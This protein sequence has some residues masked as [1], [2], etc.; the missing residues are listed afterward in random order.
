MRVQQ[1]LVVAHRVR[2]RVLHVRRDEN[3]R[4]RPRHAMAKLVGCR[5]RALEELVLQAEVRVDVALAL[6]DRARLAIAIAGLRGVVGHAER[7]IAVETVRIRRRRRVRIAWTVLRPPRHVWQRRVGLV[8]LLV[9]ECGVADL[10]DPRDVGRDRTERH[11]MEEA[12][13]VEARVGNGAR[14]EVERHVAGRAEVERARRRRR[15]RLGRPHAVV[16]RDELVLAV[17]VQVEHDRNLAGRAAVRVRHAGCRLAIERHVPRAAVVDDEVDLAIPVHVAEQR[18]VA[19]RAAELEHVLCRRIGLGVDAPLAAAKDHEVVLA[20]AIDVGHQRDVGCKPVR[21]GLVR[22]AIAIEVE[23]PGP[24]PIEHGAASARAGEIAE[25][26]HVPGLPEREGDV[27]SR[28][29]VAVERERARRGL[30]HAYG[31]PSRDLGIDALRRHQQRR[32]AN[33]RGGGLE[34]RVPV[35]GDL[36]AR[37][38]QHGHPRSELPPRRRRRRRP[39]ALLEVRART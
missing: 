12:C 17:G 14:P 30:E 16:E 7:V 33:E 18:Y 4:E 31:G 22:N 2:D 35:S 28:I 20:V 37:G 10:L 24:R 23:H 34:E 1:L 6:I 29:E 9:D 32:R 39:H 26:R 36:R 13:G 5:E 19:A 25:Q 11:L 38:L 3:L 15:D 8:E 21:N 27:G